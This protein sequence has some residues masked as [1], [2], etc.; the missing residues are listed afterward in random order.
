M[1][2]HEILNREAS[3]RYQLL[4]R[5]RTDCEYYLGYG[6]RHE[7][8]LWSGDVREQISTMRAIMQ[9]FPIRELPE[10]LTL[11]QID[12]YAAKMIPLQIAS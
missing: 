1:E 9:S 2:L 3:F 12:E 11:E 4:D 6:N 10:W 7:K 8:Y 5:L